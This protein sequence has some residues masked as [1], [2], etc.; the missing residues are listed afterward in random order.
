M[1]ESK[2]E[3]KS[4]LQYSRE[5]GIEGQDLFCTSSKDST[6]MRHDGISTQ[7]K[8]FIKCIAVYKEY[9]LFCEVLCSLAVKTLVVSG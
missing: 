9:E 1:W 4:S 3:R 7:R 8:N 5:D 6:R 2:E